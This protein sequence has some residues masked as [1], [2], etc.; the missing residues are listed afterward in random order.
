MAPTDKV[1]Y[2][3]KV[4]T[5]GGRDGGAARSSEGRLDIRL[6]VPGT[7]GT[8]TNPEQLLAAGWSTCFVSSSKFVAGRMKVELP[9]DLAVDAEVELCRNDGGFFLQARINVGLP[10]IERELAQ[11]LVAEADQAC[12]YS[13]ATRGNI[14]VAINVATSSA[15]AAALSVAWVESLTNTGVRIGAK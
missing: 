2:S 14:G 1:Q 9:L 15:R 8:G 12:P 10:G 4:H 3:A 11:N 6:S 5:T 7:P 13:K